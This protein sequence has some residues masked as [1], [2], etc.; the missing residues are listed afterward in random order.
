[1]RF[2]AEL[3]G[4]HEAAQRFDLMFPDTGVCGGAE[5]FD[6]P[7]QVD[8]SGSCCVPTP[9]TIRLEATLCSDVVM[10]SVLWR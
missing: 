10:S 9:Q 2:V 4:D 1:M 3:A 8:N 6:A 5:V 7:E